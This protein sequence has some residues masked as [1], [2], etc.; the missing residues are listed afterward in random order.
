[1]RCGK[2]EPGDKQK[3]R[4]ENG[5]CDPVYVSHGNSSPTV[6]PRTRRRSTARLT[7][8]ALICFC[9]R[10]FYLSVAK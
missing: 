4:D 7:G 5:G 1:M 10:P 6:D 8:A 2:A 3:Q 9:L